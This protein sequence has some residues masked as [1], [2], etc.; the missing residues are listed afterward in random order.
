MKTAIWFGDRDFAFLGRFVRGWFL[1]GVLALA[2][3]VATN[4]QNVKKSEPAAVYEY[5]SRGG[6]TMGLR[7]DTNLV[8]I[9]SHTNG[10]ALALQF[11]QISRTNVTYRWRSRVRASGPLKEGESSFSEAFQPPPPP[12]NRPRLIRVGPGGAPD[13][14]TF[15]AGGLQIVWEPEGQKHVRLLFTNPTATV[16]LNET[17]ESFDTLPK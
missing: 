3:G 17:G 6:A 2:W 8:A 9:I 5:Y 12:S 15:P 7:V 14:R 10:T 1:L 16:K 11:T 13:L 4:G